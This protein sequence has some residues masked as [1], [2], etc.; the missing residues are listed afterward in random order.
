MRESTHSFLW[1]KYELNVRNDIEFIQNKMREKKSQN[2]RKRKWWMKCN[3][4]VESSE[5]IKRESKE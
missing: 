2:I 4:K 3:I 1:G 5:K